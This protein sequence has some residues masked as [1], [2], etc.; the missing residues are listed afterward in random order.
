MCAQFDRVLATTLIPVVLLG[1]CGLVFLC[2]QFLQRRRGI[3]WRRRAY[4]ASLYICF[5]LYPGLVSTLLASIPCDDVAPGVS[6]L[7]V[8][9]SI[10]CH[11]QRYVNM[12][13]YTYWMIAGARTSS[14]QVLSGYVVH[15][16]SSSSSDAGLVGGIPLY[17]SAVLWSHRKQIYPKNR[18]RVVRV[19]ES[20]TGLVVLDVNYNAI[21]PDVYRSFKASLGTLQLLGQLQEVLEVK[22]PAVRDVKAWICV[23]RHLSVC[24]CCVRSGSQEVHPAWTP[25]QSLA[26]PETHSECL[27]RTI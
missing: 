6:Y 25:S 22:K 4:T 16:S 5:Y 2:A 27:R 20:G 3:R 24:F 7:R 18:N 11:S 23:E 17:F 21:S 26:G 9:L 1:L 15:S 8:D 13:T 10:E 19:T 12:T 14:S